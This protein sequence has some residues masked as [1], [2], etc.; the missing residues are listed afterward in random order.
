[1]WHWCLT[2]SI[3]AFQAE[4]AGSN[5]VCH[6]ILFRY[7]GVNMK[8]NIVCSTIR[9]VTMAGALTILNYMYDIGIIGFAIVGL[10]G[11]IWAITANIE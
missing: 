3:S 4:G 2:V 9:I 10:T 6:S 5:P 7:V 11:A 1:M 8:K